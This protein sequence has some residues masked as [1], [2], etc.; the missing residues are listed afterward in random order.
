MDL[1]MA[2]KLYASGTLGGRFNRK[3]TGKSDWDEARA[4]AATW[5][6]ARS[7]DERVYETVMPAA[8]ISEGDKQLT[9]QDVAEAYVASRKNLGIAAA[10]L[11]K[12]RTLMKQFRSYCDSW[13]TY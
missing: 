7:W 5:E 2:L 4:V 12:D 3:Q 13:A 9:I 6:A 11:G 1:A 10:T 8:E